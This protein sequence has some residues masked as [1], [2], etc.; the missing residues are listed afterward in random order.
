MTSNMTGPNKIAESVM[1]LVTLAFVMKAYVC[2]RAVVGT[3]AE[4]TPLVTVGTTDVV[5]S[6]LTKVTNDPLGRLP[7]TLKVNGIPSAVGVPCVAVKAGKAFTGKAALV[8]GQDLINEAA[9][10]YTEFKPSA[11]PYGLAAATSPMLNRCNE[12][13]KAS[14]MTMERATARYVLEVMRGAAP[15]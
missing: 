2:P 10:V 1:E 11:V 5:E 8:L 4:M 7:A 12:V 3:I 15:I 13:C 14:T 6:P 9:R